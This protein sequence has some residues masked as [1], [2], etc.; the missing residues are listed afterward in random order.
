MKV[1]LLFVLLI[2]LVT[3][4]MGSVLRLNQATDSVESSESNGQLEENGMKTSATFHRRYYYPRYHYP[5]YYRQPATGYYN[6][7]T[8]YPQRPAYYNYANLP[9]TGYTYTYDSE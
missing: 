4:A 6:R 5:T 1:K 3:V 2:Q 9:T 8:Y 7:P